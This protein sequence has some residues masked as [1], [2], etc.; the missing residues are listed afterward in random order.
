[1]N[2]LRIASWC[3]VA[4]LLAISIAAG[5]NNAA[6][7]QQGPPNG[8]Q[9]VEV[10]TR[11]PV[12]EAF[13][14]TVT[15]DPEPGFIA[16]ERAAG[17]DRGAAAGAAARKAP[18]WL[19]FPA[20]GRGTTSATISCGSAAFGERYHPVVSGCPVTGA[21]RVKAQPMDI[22]LLGRCAR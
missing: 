3:I 9:G 7:V 22:G 16:P 18:T 12:H 13:A 1:M 8:Q 6:A 14:E 19:G 21:G 2:V 20:T 4:T 17:A 15:F 5:L 10:L 11:G